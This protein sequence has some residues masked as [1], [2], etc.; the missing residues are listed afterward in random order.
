MSHLS[1]NT[2]PLLA[3]LLIVTLSALPI[4]WISVR[5]DKNWKEQMERS[6]VMSMMP[7]YR[8]VRLP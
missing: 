7:T 5:V 8:D 6:Y 4:Y 2:R 1:A 3:L